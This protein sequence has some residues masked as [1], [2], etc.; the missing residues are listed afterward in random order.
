MRI[1]CDDLP[2]TTVV[3]RGWLYRMP[4]ASQVNVSELSSDAAVWFGS[5]WVGS[6]LTSLGVWLVF[7]SVVVI[8]GSCGDLLSMSQLLLFSFVVGARLP[9]APADSEACVGASAGSAVTGAGAARAGADNTAAC[10]L[11]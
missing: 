8:T 1:H 9:L 5:V 3:F 2:L 4:L 10:S 7:C 11:D 6:L